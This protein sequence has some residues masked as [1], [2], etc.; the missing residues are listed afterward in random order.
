MREKKEEGDGRNKVSL[1]TLIRYEK[2]MFNRLKKLGQ[3]L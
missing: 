3:C 2:G 1:S